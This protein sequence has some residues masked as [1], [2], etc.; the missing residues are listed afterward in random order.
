MKTL[1]FCLLLLAGKTGF[2]QEPNRAI[3]DSDSRPNKLEGL[4]L[5]LG[6]GA[7]LL[8]IGSANISGGLTAF[9][10]RGWG[11]SFGLHYTTLNSSNVPAD[12]VAG[13]PFLGSAGPID[14]LFYSFSFMAVRKH[15]PIEGRLFRWG[16]AAGPAYVQH[17]KTEFTRRPPPTSSGW[18]FSLGNPGNYSE[19]WALRNTIGLQLEVNAT[20]LPGRAAGLEANLWGNLNAAQSLAGVEVRLLLG[21]VDSRFLVKENSS[22][23]DKPH[24]AGVC[25]VISGG[26]PSEVL[27]SAKDTLYNIPAPVHP[28]LYRPVVL[29]VAFRGNHHFSTQRFSYRQ[30]LF[31]IVS[32]VCQ[33][34]PGPKTFYQLGSLHA[35]SSLTPG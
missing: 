3:L 22:N 19:D 28:V 9:L 1:F 2:A 31:C 34:S 33:D 25:L 21:C 8:P 20:F 26:N 16:W 35:I 17:Y 12:Y 29:T 14:D 15:Y 11:A 13:T 6:L 24:I 18:G 23:S 5:N 32:P 7:A 30:H 27:D 4:Y 10:Q